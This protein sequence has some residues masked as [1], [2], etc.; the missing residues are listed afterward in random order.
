MRFV[1]SGTGAMVGSSRLLVEVDF[2]ESS[3]DRQRAVAIVIC[4]ERVILIKAMQTRIK[5]DCGQRF[6]SA[7]TESIVVLEPKPKE[8][9]DW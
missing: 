7:I 5:G 9:Q 1:H 4:M 2:L 8:I 3:S 6:E